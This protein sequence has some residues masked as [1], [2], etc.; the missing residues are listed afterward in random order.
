MIN[1][2]KYKIGLKICNSNFSSDFFNFIL[3]DALVLIVLIIN[4]YL[5]VSKGMWITREQNIETIYQA[6]ERISINEENQYFKNIKEFNI[7]FLYINKINEDKK[8]KLR[9]NKIYPIENL[10]KELF[11]INKTKPNIKNDENEQQINELSEKIKIDPKYDETKKNYFKKLFPN[12]RNEKPGDDYYISYSISLLLICVFIIIFYTSMVQDKTFGSIELNTK[13]FSGEMVICLL[14]HVIILVYERILYISQNKNTLTPKYILYDKESKTPLTD[15]ECEEYIKN[16][17]IEIKNNFIPFDSIQKIKEKYNILYIQEEGLNSP[18]VQKYILQILNVFSVHIFLFF[19]CPMKGNFNMFNS[20]FCPD[21]DEKSEEIDYISDEK[22]CN[23]FQNN[24]ALIVLYLLYIIY[25]VFSGLQIKYGFYDIKRKSLLKSG[26]SS[27]NGT[28]YKI[29]KQIPFLPEIKL[30]IDWTFTKTSLDFFQWNKFENIYDVVYCTYCSMNGKNEQEVGKKI[31]KFKK[32]FMGGGLTFFLVFVLIMPIILFSSL[33]PTNK[34][35]N[36]TGASLKIDLGFFYKNGVIKNYTLFENSKPESIQDFLSNDKSEWEKFNYANSFKTKNFPLEQVQT[37]KFFEESDKNWD[38][39]YPHIY[40]LRELILNRGNISD[41]EYIGLILDYNFD[42]PLPV[43][44]MKISKRYSTT[45]YYKDNHTEEQD[46]ILDEIGDALFNCNDVEVEFKNI[47]SPPI[48]LSATSIPKRIIDEKYFPNLDIRI[49]FI[50]KNKQNI[51]D[52][53]KTSI[54][55]LGSYF[56]AKKRLNWK[57]HEDIG[58]IIFHVF[59]DKVSSTTSGRT[60]L[61]FYVSFVLLL[62]TYIRNFLS[63]NPE[64][65]MLTEMPHSEDIITLCEGI[66]YARYQSDYEQEE[67]LYYNL[68]EIMRSPDYIRNVTDSSIKQFE[69]RKKLTK[70]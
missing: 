8:K 67:R 51:N 27:I 52:D 42:R 21:I 61:T 33:N 3:Y 58:G 12:I 65:V 46:K 6:M 68:I 11:Q 56:T 4:N 20:I 66:K 32:I 29:F 47:Y 30:S 41:L 25:L 62:G 40:N 26:K 36:L 39:T 70:I 10:Y 22:E 16:E 49:G 7:N 60:I 44:S 53:N 64:K 23:D 63:S 57:G 59:S 15:S 28:I 1:F 19:Y 2:Y 17:K 48:R 34:L 45:I 14:I 35:N 31:K 69:D 24:N 54:N 50:C 37:V 9:F 5:L 43:E 18:S 55:Y 38:L 13:Q